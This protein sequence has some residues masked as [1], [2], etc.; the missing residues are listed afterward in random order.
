MKKTFISLII[1]TF[2]REFQLIKILTSIKKQIFDEINIEVIICDSF[3]EYDQTRFPKNNE[4]FTLKYF[5]IDKNN[6]SAKRNFGIRNSTYD[7]IILLDDDCVPN[8]NFLREYVNAFEK[9]DKKTILS[10]IVEYPEDHIKKFNHIKYKDSRHFKIDHVE[11]DI[12]LDPDKIVAM[13]M[14]FIKSDSMKKI[15]FF[16]ERFT[17]YGFEDYEFGYR[18]K[19]NGY[20]LKCVRAS[21]LHD[22]GKPNFTKYMKKYFHLGRDGMKNLQI[23]DI[24]SAKETVYYKIEEKQLFKLIK[25]IPKL[26]C[27]LSWIEKLIEKT[28]KMLFMNYS[29]IFTLARL[30]SYTRGYIEREKYFLNKNNQDWYE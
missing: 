26:N 22:E 3:S 9:I 4:N 11:K 30:C 1:P 21:I 14:G 6:L 10:G 7:N 2:K 15:G 13:N 12:D 23:V 20:L 8:K 29:F 27:L 18:Y 24:I 28:D 17:G 19:K 5:N 25:K 16:D